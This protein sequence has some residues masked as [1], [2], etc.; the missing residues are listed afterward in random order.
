MRINLNAE[1]RISIKKLTDAD[2]N[3]SITTNQTHIGIS[4]K[5][6]TFMGNSKKTHSAILVHNNSWFVEQCDIGRITRKNGSHNALKISMGGRNKENLVKR[7]RKI[8]ST[9][10]HTHYMIWFAADTEV[11]VFWLIRKGSVDYKKL[12]DIIDFNNVNDRICT[13]DNHDREFRSIVNIINET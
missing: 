2:L 13:F 10:R 12:K 4:D 6:F 7:I 8:A 9:N 11:P 1:R 5:S 3:R